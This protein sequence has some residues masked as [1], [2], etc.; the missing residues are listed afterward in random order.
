MADEAAAVTS[1]SGAARLTAATCLTNSRRSSFGLSLR[2]LPIFRLLLPDFLRSGRFVIPPAAC[3]LCKRERFGTKN[4]HRLEADA[5]QDM[6]AGIR[7][8]RPRRFVRS[9]RESQAI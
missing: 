7:R 9:T 6:L 4:N 3:N 5:D 2:R 1:R 8:T